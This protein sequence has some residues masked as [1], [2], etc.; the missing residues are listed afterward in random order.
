MKFLFKIG[1]GFLLILIFWSLQTTPI[2]LAGWLYPGEIGCNDTSDCIPNPGGEAHCCLPGSHMCASTGGG[3]YCYS[4]PDPVNGSCASTHYNCSA[5]NLG[6]TAEYS[7]QWQWLCNGRDGGSNVL[8]AEMKPNPP[9]NGGWSGWSGWYGCSVSACGQTGTQYR[10]RYCNNPSP[11]NGGSYCSGSDTDS[12]SCSTAACPLATASCSVSPNPLTNGGNPGITLYSS[13][14]Y[15]C[16]VY[17]DGANVNTG[18]FTSGTYYP[19]AQTTPGAHQASVYCYNQSWVGS[20]WNYC[21]YTVNYPPPTLG[22][23]TISSASVNPNNSTQYTI[24][25]SG[26][27]TGGVGKVLSLLGLINYQG[28]NV[29]NYRGYLMWNQ[30]SSSYWSASESKLCGGSGGIGIIYSGGYGP[31]YLHLDSCSV[32]DAGTTRT[33]SFVVRFDPSF[34]TPIIDNDISGY[35]YDDIWQGAGWTNFQ[36]NFNLAFTPVASNVTISSAS[37]NPNNSTQYNIVA[38]GTDLGGGAN[39]THEYALINYQGGNAGNYRGYLTWYYDGAYTGW[40]LPATKTKIACTGGGIAAIQFGYGDSYINL[41]SCATSVVGNTRITTFVVRFTPSFTTPTT[42]N[43]ISEYVQNTNGIA[44]GWVNFDLNFGLTFSA[45]NVPT[46]SGATSG[47]P[48]TNYTNTFT[49]TDPNGY[50]VRYGIDWSIPADGVADE[51]LPAGVSYVN[52]GVSQSSSHSWSTIGAK[53]IKALTQNYQGTNSAWS[54]PYSVSIVNAP[55]TGVCGSANKSYPQGSSSYGSDTYCSAGTPS[56]SPA[57][58]APGAS[59]TW[60][61]L[62]SNGGSDSPLCTATLIQT[63]YSVTVVKTTGGTTKS[64]DNIITCGNTCV[65]NYNSGSVV[66]LKAIP[67]SSYWRFVQWTGDCSGTSPTCVLNVNSPKSAT[68]IFGLTRFNYQEF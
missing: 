53:T 5:G 56:S 20:G 36:T 19:G 58:P 42:N 46:I 28:E 67:S 43:D 40:N 29:G 32:S 34:T 7:N 10:Y 31:S 61:C 37:V 27:S 55:I 68:A 39:I 2:A 63:T 60:T 38:T 11:A 9:V 8:C 59:V 25:V 22:N 49:A 35:V 65:N 44:T 64:V 51:W 33:V 3:P 48:S 52:S 16:Y 14:G 18:Y 54:S 23:V 62:G 21:S 12:Q 26:S 1:F 24:T 47:Y 6:A 15:Y 66:T 50:Q 57:F 13:N 30:G 45:P 4:P 17:N 41:D